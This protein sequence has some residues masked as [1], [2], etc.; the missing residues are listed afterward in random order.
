MQ[1]QES[2]KQNKRGRK[3]SVML[4]MYD[5]ALLLV[6]D[7]L[8]LVIYPSGIT[9]L[10]PVSIVV[11]ALISM[12]GIMFGRMVMGIY[13]Q[14][15]RYGG[16]T[17]YM[18]LIIADAL[19]GLI[20]LALM[21]LLPFKR[22]TA[23]RALALVAINLLAAIAMR[24]VYQYMYEYSSRKSIIAKIMRKV[25]R[26]LTG[27]KIDPVQSGKISGHRINIAIVGAGRVGVMLADELLR[28]PSAAYQ[29]CCFI[30]IDSEKIGRYISGLRVYS[31]AEFTPDVLASF[32][33]QEIVFAMPDVDIERKQQLYA[34]YKTTGCKIKV[35]DYPD[36][37][38]MAGSK[39]TLREFDIAELL[40]RQPVEFTDERT[41]NYY[42]GKTVL[43]SGGGGSIGSEL[44]RQIAKMH[45]KRLVI[46]DV[47][48][49]GAYDIQQE[50]RIRYGEK[51][52]LVV[53]IA[54][55]CD[56][57]SLEHIFS[58]HRPDVVLHAAAHKHVPLMERNC[59][60]AV[61]N[62][63]FGTLN[64]VEVSEK[65]GVGKFTMISTDKAVNPTNVM[66]ATKRMCEMIVQSRKGTK[67]NFSATRFGNVLGSNG[68]VI[69][70]FKRQIM[71]GGP[72]T[73][74]DKRIIR[75]F[76]TI[77]EASQLV[78][79]SGAMAKNGELYVLDM[80]KPVKILELAENMIR[81]SGFEPYKDI[82]I[83]ETGL[84]PGEKLYEE[85]LIK[86][87]ELDKT[88]NSM[89]FVER[90]KP[91]TMDIIDK[92]LEVLSAAVETDDDDAVRA[93]LHEVVP[94]FKTPEEINAEASKAEEMNAVD[95]DAAVAM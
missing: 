78:L 6:A 58:E 10:D 72:V 44:C 89:I 76:M 32:P 42:R 14:I 57:Q 41:K 94:T 19:G 43:I 67:T 90:D 56:R 63:V 38:K 70:L 24:F 23:L 68:S 66:G 61:K 8:M 27:I 92:K 82:D 48:E 25:A 7:L 17:Q 40:F 81:L 95:E 36:P 74:T 77:P 87:E 71:N 30:D 59:V 15:W 20:Y 37:Q 3:H 5:L 46:L 85:L 53:E 33:I 51:L 80:G 55:V 35:Y 65:Y 4:M 11:Q 28:N 73:L 52:D 60:E 88:S 18:R 84:R 86:T 39:R 29:P 2:Q 9:K 21:Y 69:P 16:T 34:Q 91:L 22:I 50:L 1:E 47:Y 93:A 83:V 75:Y 12:A 31:E 45:P 26:V 79:Q 54:T 64:I 13:K 49:N 62:N